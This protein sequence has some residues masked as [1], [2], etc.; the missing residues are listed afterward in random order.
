MYMLI[1]SDIRGSDRNAGSKNI[2]QFTKYRLLCICN[3]IPL[4]G[5]GALLALLASLQREQLVFAV[6]C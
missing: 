1:M 6:G 3:S 5:A 2:Y 4:V